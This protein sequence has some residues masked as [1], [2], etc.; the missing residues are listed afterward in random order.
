VRL[1]SYVLSVTALRILAAAA[2][3]LGVLQ[4]LDLLDVTTE[5]LD[6]GLGVGGVLYHSTLRLPRMLEQ[7][8]PLSVLAGG[9]FA[10]GQLARENAVTAM[11]ASG[12]SIYRLLAMTVPAA[13]CVVVIDYAAV[14]LIAPRTD[15]ALETW[16]RATA[17][18]E[19]R[20]ADEPRAF[21]SGAD[22]VVARAASDRGARLD[23]V[24]IY[25][26]NANG[27]LSERIA[28]PYANYA[29]GGWRLHEPTMTRFTQDEALTS[30]AA[31]L[32]WPT[33]LRPA[34]V[35]SLLSQAQTPS[36]A[37]AR[38]ALSGGASERP[39]S[40]YAVRVHRALAEPIGILV[41]LLLTAPVALGN[42]RNR[43]G[44]ILSAS[45]LAAGLAFLV[46]DGLLTALGESGALAPVLAAWTAPVVFAAFATTVLLRMEG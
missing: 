27:Q 32:A 5:I 43:Q 12:V 46:V 7:V 36:A 25:R 44:A 10:F 3:L 21:R 34:D 22:L 13:L 16:W 42:F 17:P 14:E 31:A 28:A 9:L 11:R 23:D 24:K 29:D 4:I 35:Q 26:R 38:R 30:S 37:T 19:K 2:I 39:E 20:D 1:Y 18:A 8:A 33:R 15:P 6:R 45:S 40:Y 41:M